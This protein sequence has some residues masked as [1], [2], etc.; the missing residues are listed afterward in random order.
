MERA[1]SSESFEPAV[2]LKGRGGRDESEKKSVAAEKNT[3]TRSA[4]I[5]DYSFHRERRIS[6]NKVERDAEKKNYYYASGG[7]FFSY[8]FVFKLETF[9]FFSSTPFAVQNTRVQHLYI[10]HAQRVT[11]SLHGK[12]NGRVLRRQ[13]SS[14]GREKKRRTPPAG[15]LRTYIRRRIRLNCFRCRVK[16]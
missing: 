14:N 1:A 16:A 10:P 6:V 7:F 9:F 13:L 2:N 4:V 12:S 15:T 3:T 11:R 8:F 5:P